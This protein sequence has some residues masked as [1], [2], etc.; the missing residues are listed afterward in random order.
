M[1]IFINAVQF[2]KKHQ[3]DK[4]ESILKN[5]HWE[6]IAVSMDASSFYALSCSSGDVLLADL[7]KLA[8][9]H[10]AIIGLNGIENAKRISKQYRKF[11]F[12]DKAASIDLDIKNVEACQ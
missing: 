4:V 1:S 10:R 7:G 6:N 11:G 2:W 3:Q 12:F 9:S 5:A 8:E